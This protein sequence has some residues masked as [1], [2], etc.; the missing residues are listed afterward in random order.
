MALLQKIPRK[1]LQDMI[2]ITPF[3]IK[4]GFSALIAGA[5]IAMKTIKKYWES[6]V[7]TVRISKEQVA[8]IEGMK[9]FIQPDAS[10]G[11]D[12]FVTSQYYQLCCSLLECKKDLNGFWI[13]NGPPNL[14]SLA[15]YGY[16]ENTTMYIQ[17]PELTSEVATMCY[18][19]AG[20]QET[21]RTSF[22][23]LQPLFENNI[24]TLIYPVISLCLIKLALLLTSMR[25]ITEET[26]NTLSAIHELLARLYER[27]SE[28]YKKYAPLSLKYF[29]GFFSLA[30]NLCEQRL[31]D[32]KTQNLLEQVRGL[33]FM[34]AT[35]AYKLAI[36]ILCS[37][38]ER[39]NLVGATGFLIDLDVISTRQKQRRVTDKGINW[40]ELAHQIKR[41]FNQAEYNVLLS[42][43]EKRV[44]GQNTGVFGETYRFMRL[45]MLNTN[46]E[47]SGQHKLHFLDQSTIK[48][49]RD[50]IVVQK[51]ISKTG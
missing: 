39:V 12:K 26:V 28:K 29:E 15:D 32:S 30:K 9:N 6:E 49:L 35:R 36:S 1:G 48:D 3:L 24:E 19:F 45:A 40:Q 38:T 5:N 37:D 27:S 41:L 4:A 31:K 46:G 17:N 8:V 43:Q 23:V 42:D 34:N 47:I 14:R 10:S 18:Y 11:I 7:G 13:I 2:D 21:S 16:Y 51:K 25:V 20:V 44:L 33:T 50:K 22:C